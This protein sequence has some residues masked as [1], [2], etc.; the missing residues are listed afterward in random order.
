MDKFDENLS[1]TAAK[2][3]DLSGKCICPECPTYT[4]CTGEAK[5]LLYCLN[6]QSFHCITEDLGC[7]CPAC[8]L[9]DELGLMNLTFCLLGSE[10]SQ[11]M[12][13]KIGAGSPLK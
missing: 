1:N 10:S 7:V 13:Q 12:E 11:R 2:A 5:E 4:S 8:P 6:G 9:A 3:R